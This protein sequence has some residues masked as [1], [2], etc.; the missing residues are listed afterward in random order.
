MWSSYEQRVISS[1]NEFLSVTAPHREWLKELLYRQFDVKEGRLVDMMKIAE[2]GYFHPRMKGKLSIKAVLPAVLN[3]QELPVG[4]RVHVNDESVVL[5]TK[6][7]YSELGALL[8]A[9]LGIAVTNGSD[10]II[11]YENMHRAQRKQQNFIGAAKALMSYC[12]LDTLAMV[13][14]FKHWLKL[15]KGNPPL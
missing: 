1:V 2:H 11:A 3:A 13:T 8:E 6:N 5:S 12:E 14:I 10:A 9:S 15:V 7:P 4:V